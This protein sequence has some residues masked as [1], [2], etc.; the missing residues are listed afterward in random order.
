MPSDEQHRVGGVA[1]EVERLTQADIVRRLV[2]TYDPRA[3]CLFASRARGNHQLS[4]YYDLLVVVPNG[5]PKG[6]AYRCAD[7]GRQNG[8]RR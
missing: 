4:S 6:V 3:I 5:A 7:L 1:E 2:A 8:G